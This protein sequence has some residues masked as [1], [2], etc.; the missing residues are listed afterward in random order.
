MESFFIIH[1][2][3]TMTSDDG[4][5][6]ATVEELAASAEFSQ[7]DVAEVPAKTE[8]PAATEA[9]KEE[10]KEGEEEVVETEEKADTDALSDA[11]LANVDKFS[12]LDEPER[13]E[14]IQKMLVSGRKD[15]VATAK[16]LMDSFGMEIEESESTTDAAVAESLK[17]M[18]LTPE[19]I[20]ELQTQKE[21]EE[22][23][24]SVEV[25]AK[26]LG[27]P[28]I[29]TILKNKDFVKAYHSSDGKVQGKVDAAIKAYLEKNPVTDAAKKLATLKLASTGE[30]TTAT[31][32]KK[33]EGVD[34]IDDVLEGK[35]L[36]QIDLAK[37]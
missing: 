32:T 21:L 17:K 37:L 20:K 8:A 10:V 25:W 23:K 3:F 35:S 27:I 16:M 28:S 14:K 19:S 18:G 1:N 36:D 9:P 12:K 33:E 15:Q 30:E 2:F 29:D 7:E 34:D 26:T 22:R 4:K 13:I 6:D 31:T 11:D 24:K 5:K